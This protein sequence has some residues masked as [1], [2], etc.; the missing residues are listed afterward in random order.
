MTLQKPHEVC[1]PTSMS[2][3]V[4]RDLRVGGQKVEYGSIR[5]FAADSHTQLPQGEHIQS[6]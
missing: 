5:G 4:E 2:S 6:M 1:T 3:I